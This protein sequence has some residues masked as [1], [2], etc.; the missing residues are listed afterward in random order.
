MLRTT[1]SGPLVAILLVL[2]AVVGS[3]YLFT[4]DS[5]QPLHLLDDEPIPVFDDDHS[6]PSLIQSA[7]RQLTYLK[8]LPHEKSINFEGG[9]FSAHH[10]IRSLETLIRELHS[11][12]DL[13]QFNHFLR[14]NYHVYQAG[15]RKGQTGRQMLVTGYY[16]PLFDGSLTRVEPYIY[17]IYRVPDS[18]VARSQNDQKEVG[19]YDSNNHFLPYWSR[20]EIE[21]NDLLK[22]C[23]LVYLRDPFDAFLLHVQGSGRIK[24]EDK[25]IRAV[26]FAGSNGLEYNS[27]GK[28]LVDEKVMALE[29]VNIPAIR[30]YLEHN[31]GERQRILHHNPRYIFFNWGDSQG[32]KGSSGQ[33]LTPGRS[34]AMDVSALPSGTIGYLTSRRPLTDSEGTITGW[35]PLHRFVFPQDTGA[36]I[37]GTGRVDLFWGSGTYARTAANNMKEDGKLYFLVLRDVSDG[38]DGKLLIDDS[39]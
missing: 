30:M 34:I 29:E 23:E 24:L 37:K 35:T 36:A 31:P 19:R 5:F 10:L 33:V 14:N 18:L 28:L 2:S 39:N 4:W 6:L 21:N 12:P 17:P 27:I 13:D 20:A 22:G 25:S 26:R 7:E 15:G 8:K 38:A 11:K 32:P 16:E 1:R 3:Y 9:S